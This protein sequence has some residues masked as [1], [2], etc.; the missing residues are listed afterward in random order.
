V[1]NAFVIMPSMAMRTLVLTSLLMLF[2]QDRPAFEVASIKE[3]QFV[4]GLMGVDFEPGGRMVARQA[5]TPLL[6]QAAFRIQRWQLEFSK[7]LPKDAVGL[8]DIEAKPASSA[9]PPGALSRDSRAKLLL[10]LQSLLIDR[11]NLK[12]HIEKRELPIYAL[13]VDKGGLK[14]P[15][16]PDRNCDVTPSPCRWLQAGPASGIVGQS[17]T[18][19]GLAG[20]LADFGDRPIINKT[21]MD[22]RFDIKIA[23]YSR[24][25]QTPGT[26]VDG[27]A[28][29]LSLPSLA[30][31]LQ[32]AGLRMEQQKQL[33]DVYI[34]DHVEKPSAN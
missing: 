11:F 22:G 13:V 23:P 1:T 15:K 10:M 33:L 25:A 14:F 26:L 18:L 32:D 6:I 30:S 12:F 5:P 4:P 28:A 7:D 17:V 8:F 19:E 2:A 20:M 21:G 16:A 9:I 34:I 29:D 24:G 3:K 31:V 27:V